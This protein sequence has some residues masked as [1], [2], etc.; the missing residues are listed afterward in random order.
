MTTATAPTAELTIRDRYDQAERNL[1]AAESRL[2]ELREG[3]EQFEGALTAARNA[4]LTHVLRSDHGAADAADS[5]IRRLERECERQKILISEAE[6]EVHDFEQKFAPIAD[7]HRREAHAREEAAAR[8]ALFER[9]RRFA[10][11]YK[12]A[13]HAWALYAI[14]CEAVARRFGHPIVNEA[15]ALRELEEIR[16][17][18]LNCGWKQPGVAAREFW[19]RA[20]LPPDAEIPQLPAPASGITSAP[21]A[22]FIQHNPPPPPRA[23]TSVRA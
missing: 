10:S 6:A 4:R 3:L 7:E 17:G 5:E 22:Q 2:K 1:R 14:D 11:L 21:A 23:A 18:L 12:E 9:A 20:Y 15:N 8:E 16:I 19:L 13:T